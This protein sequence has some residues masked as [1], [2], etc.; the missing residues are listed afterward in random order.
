MSVV[1]SPAVPLPTLFTAAACAFAA[2]A[3]VTAFSALSCAAV[4]CAGPAGFAWVVVEVELE[5]A[6]VDVVFAA[7][8][9]AEPPSARAAKAPP[10]ARVFLVRSNILGLLC[11]ARFGMF[12]VQ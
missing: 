8:A 11:L 3:P 9:I 4:P 10:M 5:A 6:P 7:P 1:T 2:L 12:R